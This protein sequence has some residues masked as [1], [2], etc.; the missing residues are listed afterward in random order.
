MARDYYEVLGVPRGA[1]AAEIKKAYRRLARKHHPDVNPGN[2][3]AEQRFKEVQEAYGVLSDPDKR[4][5]YDTFGRVQDQPGADGGPF[6]AGGGGWGDAGGF[7]VDFDDLGGLGGLGGIFGDLFGRGREAAAGRTRRRRSD[8]QEMTVE[9][10]FE[11]AVRGASVTLPV[12]RPVRCSE[13][14]GSRR[15]SARPCPACHGAGVVIATERLRVRIPEGIADG[16]RVR[17]A[18]K[19]GEGAADGPAGD[20]FVR[21]RVRPHPFFRRDG[22]NV[23]TTVPI[24]FAE[25]YRGAEIEVGTVHGPVRAKLPPGTDS[26]RTFRLR[27]KGVRNTKT[28]AF[29]DHLYTVEIVVP[30]VLSPAGQE[31]ARRVADLYTGDPRAGLPTG[32]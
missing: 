32:L 22:D 26:G 4:Q 30:K 13:C 20:L 31:A 6:R 12:Q 27:G 8:D 15:T 3:A 1:S 2:A 21:V 19:G 9:V 11:D 10:D 28:R 14:G 25:A 7:R 18:G 17:L 5:Q 24:T 29:G 23:L 16:N